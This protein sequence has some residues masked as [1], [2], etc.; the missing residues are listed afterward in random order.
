MTK[1][2]IIDKSD[3]HDLLAGKALSL[4]QGNE[5]AFCITISGDM[6]NGDMI[7]ALYP[8]VILFTNGAEIGFRPKEQTWVIWFHT[9]W[10]NAP[11]RE[12][13]EG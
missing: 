9:D 10:W 6:T 13:D 8:G 3:I 2:Y 5:S 4:S 7:K 11:Y 12:E 1:R